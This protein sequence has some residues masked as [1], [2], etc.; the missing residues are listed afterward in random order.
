[1]TAS[2]HRFILLTDLHLSDNPDTAAHQALQWAVDRVNLERPDFLAVAGDVTTFSTAVSAVRCLEALDRVEVP[3]LFTPGNAERRG[4]HAMSVFETLAAPGR[5]VALFGDLQVL[6]PDTSTGT[7]LDDERSWL[8]RSLGS[9]H[10]ERRM[11]ITHYPLDRMDGE[12][13][14][15]LTRW[16][17]ENG[18]ELLVAGHSHFHRTRRENG[19]V[20]AVVR[21]LDPDKAIGDLPGISLFESGQD[22][23]WTETFIPWSPAIRLL[24]ADLPNG[25]Q[26]VGWSIQG[27]PVM[28]ARKTCGSGLSCL[29]IRPADLDFSRKALSTA[30]CD[31]RDQGPLYLSYHLPDLRWNSGAR[32]VDGVD[33]VR[34]HLD[35]AMEAGAD[36]LTVHVP[37]AT[38]REMERVR[39][40]RMEATGCFFTF[41]RTFESLFRQAV[42]EGVG[43]AIENI[44]NPDNTP[45]DSPDRE[46][47]TR[48]EEYLRWIDAVAAEVADLPG[49]R[50][51]ALLDVGHARNNGGDLDNLQPLGDWYAR[52]G[53]RILG[54]HIHQVETD[55]DSGLLSN[56]H[57][58]RELFGSRISFAGFLWAWSTHQITRGPLFVEVRDAEGREKTVRRFRRLFENAH[59]I[60]EAADL[61]GRTT[62]ADTGA[63]DDS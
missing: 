27:D 44:H 13:R 35:C 52:L 23:A 60:R 20:E 12:G 19:F 18:V 45:A 48:I 7:L 25:M 1:M 28:A 49:A 22:G 37:R 16:L 38:A 40:H 55:P 50:V 8:D 4:R 41:A 21:G 9:N 29:E 63:D 2:V 10:A 33:A 34:A 31:L 57:E 11:V 15:W 53:R 36:S 59:R 58:I 54:Y 26:P 32:R 3:V 24:P 43:I 17:R 14:A 30:L 47:A 46:F 62:R 51:G 5:R 39:E 61:P 56:H 6:L 42:R